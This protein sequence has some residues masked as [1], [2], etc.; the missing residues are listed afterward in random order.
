MKIKICE[1]NKEEIEKALETINKKKQSHT[2]TT[3]EEIAQIAE[4]AEKDV[5]KLLGKKNI[6]NGAIVESTSGGA[7]PK[8]YKYS[9]DATCIEITRGT[10]AWF[11][12]RINSVRI[13]QNGGRE[14]IRLTKAQALSGINDFCTN[15]R[16]QGERIRSIKD[17]DIFFDKNVE[18]HCSANRYEEIF[19][20][21]EE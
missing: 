10:S 15:F 2:Y 17:K 12:T 5:F 16:V 1:K 8:C 3:Y 9:R 11:L 13:F 20:V 19:G 18:E 6:M 4:R 7:V 21:V 14:E